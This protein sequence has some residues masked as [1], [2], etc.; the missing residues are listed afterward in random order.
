MKKREIKE[1]IRQAYAAETPDLLARI[2]A[3]CKEVEQAAPVLPEEPRTAT[4]R[5]GWFARPAVRRALSFA[6]ALVLL[7]TGFSVG[8][9]LPDGT[10][11][12]GGGVADTFVYLDVNPSIELQIDSDSR[13]LACVAA[14]ADAEAVLE[15]LALVG[16]DMN[17]AMTAIIGSMY[18]NG[19]LSS[20][21]NAILVS[22]DSKGEQENE[23]LLTDLTEKISA[24]FARSEL[25]CS[26][27]AQSVDAN[28]E[29]KQ[30]AAENGVSVGK[31]LLVDKMV[32]GI[33]E[34]QASDI[35]DLLQ[36]SIK[37]LNL[38]YTHRP[39]KEGEHSPFDEDI[40]T[41]AV[42]G[43][44]GREEIL[45]V[46]ATELQADVTALLGLDIRAAMKRGEEGRSLVY[47]VRVWLGGAR[48]KLE[49]DCLTGEVLSN[50]IELDIGDIGG[51]GGIG[52]GHRNEHPDD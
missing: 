3:S 12:S 45:S 43:Y 23:Q 44:L 48:Y 4:P 24:V 19:Y 10:Q 9:L 25:E 41:G 6:L 2:E 8:Y 40:L 11:N 27:I 20:S 47:E 33:D 52:G 14:N 5:A 1:K 32:E 35:A 28:D 30:R 31:M 51:I 46:L 36:M 21:A 26:I 15:G 39:D 7:F 17:T 49:L 22:V 37:E 38:M 42:G 16:V 18:V 50:E 34:L 13:V 29:L